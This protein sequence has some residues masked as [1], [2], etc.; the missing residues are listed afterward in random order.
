[1]PIS[2]SQNGQSSHFTYG[3]E[4]Q[5]TRQDKSGGISIIYAGSMEVEGP[6]NN[7]TRI[8][9]YWPHGLGVEI[10]EA[11]ATKLYWTHLDRLGSPIAISDESG[12][13]KEKLAYDAWGKRRNLVGNA[14][15]NNLDGEVDNKGYTGHEM[16]DHLDLVHMNGR[17]YDPLLAKFVSADPHITDPLNGQNY[18]R[19]SYVLNNPT[20]LTDP[21]GF[22]WRGD[23][24]SWWSTP[25]FGKDDSAKKQQEQPKA[26]TAHT[27]AGRGERESKATN[28]G[29]E[30]KS[31]WQK[32]KDFF[33]QAMRSFGLFDGFVPS[34]ASFESDASQLLG[35][36]C[37]YNC[38]GHNASVKSTADVFEGAAQGVAE[39]GNRYY[40]ELAKNMALAAL[41]VEAIAAKAAAALAGR[42]IMLVNGFYQAEGSAF[43][44]SQYYYEKLWSTGRGA[45][46]LQADEVLKTATKVV[47]DR[48]KGFNRYENGSYEMIYNPATKEVWHLQPRKQ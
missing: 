28:N 4:H 27:A 17:V 42:E 37:D 36:P 47:P 25:W 12:T 39:A 18:N 43:K 40:P 11:S 5:R 3:P 24:K 9:T 1:M 26:D 29:T 7:P 46:F 8:K 41:P 13:I 10:E 6:L 20:N 2:I 23:I 32:T 48:M 35:G 16:L 22:D 21:T 44:F 15:P 30:S 14:T 45:P 33:G 31:T 19:Y 34:R 38:E